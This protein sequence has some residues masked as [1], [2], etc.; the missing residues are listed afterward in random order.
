MAPLRLFLTLPSLLVGLVSGRLLSERLGRAQGG[1][2]VLVP[3]GAAAYFT[4]TLGATPTGL[5][6]CAVALAANAGSSLLGRGINR[7]PA[8]PPL[9][10]TTVSMTFGSLVPLPAAAPI[11][12]L[13]APSLAAPPLL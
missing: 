3:A 4:G 12:R 6:A 1:A 13:P 10:T 2:A 7:D 9:I 5:A 11:L 8:T